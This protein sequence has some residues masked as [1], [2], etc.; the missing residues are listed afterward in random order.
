MRPHT[1]AMRQPMAA[2]GSGSGRPQAGL[3]WRHLVTALL[4][5]VVLPVVLVAGVAALA[6]APIVIALVGFQ[7]IQQLARTPRQPARLHDRR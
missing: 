3:G 2:E 5:L 7:Q 1:V 4:L 6:V